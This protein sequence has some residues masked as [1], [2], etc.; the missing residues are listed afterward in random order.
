[1]STNCGRRPYSSDFGSIYR[2]GPV[3]A[4]DRRHVD[5]FFL[6]DVRLIRRLSSPF[7]LA[8]ITILATARSRDLFIH[9]TV[10]NLLSTMAKEPAPKRR[11][12][13]DDLYHEEGKTSLWALDPEESHRFARKI[14]TRVVASFAVRP[15]KH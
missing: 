1:M 8:L 5:A 14:I 15:A 9:N 4:G 6:N 2:F 7:A 12:T 10:I 11:E 3:T 13:G